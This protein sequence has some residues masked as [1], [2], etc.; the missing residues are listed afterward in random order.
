MMAGIKNSVGVISLAVPIS[1]A[2]ADIKPTHRA[3]GARRPRPRLY[4]SANV[5]IREHVGEAA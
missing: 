5:L 2:A 1:L 4:R 3:V